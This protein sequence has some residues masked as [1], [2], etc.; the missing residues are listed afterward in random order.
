MVIVYVELTALTATFVMLRICTYSMMHMCM[1]C[2]FGGNAEKHKYN[3]EY[4]TMLVGLARCCVA[5][6]IVK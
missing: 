1:V 4:A 5:S 2:E 3:A 6:K